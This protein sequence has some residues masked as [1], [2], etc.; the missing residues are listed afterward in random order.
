MSAEKHTE[1]A[2]KTPQPSPA[3][4]KTFFTNPAMMIIQGRKR[5]DS[6]GRVITEVALLEWKG[7]ISQ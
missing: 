2:D 4:I 3:A 5:W 7:S 1:T 6:K